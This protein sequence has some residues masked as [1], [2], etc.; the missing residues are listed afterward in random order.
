MDRNYVVLVDAVYHGIPIHSILPVCIAD[1]CK[2]RHTQSTCTRRRPPLLPAPNAVH[3]LKCTRA[4]S[5]SHYISTQLNLLAQ[6][7]KS[8]LQKPL[9]LTDLVPPANVSEAERATYVP[10]LDKDE[11][12]ERFGILNC[13]KYKG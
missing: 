5:Q 8:H 9:V 1:T 12:D 3:M 4:S 11:P 7:M 10:V 2:C 13:R 6:R